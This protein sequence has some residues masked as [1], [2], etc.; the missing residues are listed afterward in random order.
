[1][2]SIFAGGNIGTVVLAKST[3]TA[4]FSMVKVKPPM[5]TK[6]GLISGISW[7]DGVN[8]QFTHTMGDDI[9]MN[10]FGN[11][12]GTLTIKGIA[13]AD[14]ECK[15]A[16]KH[17]VIDI[18]DWY[19]EQRV[20]ATGKKIVVT[21][22]GTEAISGFLVAASYST[23]DTENWLVGYQLEVATVPRAM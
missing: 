8:A 6:V 17:G 15:G 4:T 20:S 10:V 13:F 19:K 14:F 2:P 11:R 16:S 18:I 12:M 23:D 21:V 9:Y 5:P 7:Q 3:R 1:M 22:G